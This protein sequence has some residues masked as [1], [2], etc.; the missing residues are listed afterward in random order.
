MEGNR[1]C[2]W[3][4]GMTLI[5]VESYLEVVETFPVMFLAVEVSG[6]FRPNDLPRVPRRLVSF[7]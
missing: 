1:S 5:P 2:D 4:F 3:T 7:E 6:V